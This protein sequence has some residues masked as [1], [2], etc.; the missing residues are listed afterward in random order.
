MNN[1]IH[2]TYQIVTGILLE[3][4]IRCADLII[5]V[6]KTAVTENTETEPASCCSFGSY[7][8]LYSSSPFEIFKCV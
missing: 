6:C 4:R 5:Q 2:C 1:S 7:F 3:E 8:F